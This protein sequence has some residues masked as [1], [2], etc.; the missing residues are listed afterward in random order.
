MSRRWILALGLVAV[1]TVAAV[2]SV[3]K[4]TAA[5]GTGS[6]PRYLVTVTNLTYGQPF[7]PPVVAL[8]RHSVDLFDPGRRASYELQQLAENGNAGP[9]LAALDPA[10]NRA[11]NAVT[12]VARGAAG[13]APIVPKGDPGASGFASAQSFILTGGRG[14]NYVSIAS[15]LICTN[16]GFVGLDS[17]KLPRHVGDT[18][19]YFAAG[20][21][22]GTENN[23]EDFRDMVPPCQGLIGVSSSDAGT[24]ET[25]K[26]LAQNGVI[27]LHPGVQGGSDL[28]PGTHGWVDPTAMYFVERIG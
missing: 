2:V 16:D 8:H 21:D 9:L 19:T 14:A 11:V 28:V 13:P 1:L 15:M 25:N 23:T 10:N 3:V 7:T 26:D 22:A 4:V 6:A 20:Y 12:N 18:A 17:I 24:G 27:G 5:A